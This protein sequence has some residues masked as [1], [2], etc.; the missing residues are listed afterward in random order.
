VPYGRPNV[1]C[2]RYVYNWATPAA[3]C[4]TLFVSLDSGQTYDAYFK[5]S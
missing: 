5:L 2:T 3:G 4:Y 1:S